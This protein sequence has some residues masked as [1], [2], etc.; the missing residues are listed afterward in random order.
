[1]EAGIRMSVKPHS[2]MSVGVKAG[3][4]MSAGVK[5]DN[6][7]SAAVKAGSITNKADGVFRPLPGCVDHRDEIC[8]GNWSSPEKIYTRQDE[9]GIMRKELGPR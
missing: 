9:A 7:M 6:K 5:A 2:R 1:M 8:C 3:R 4:K